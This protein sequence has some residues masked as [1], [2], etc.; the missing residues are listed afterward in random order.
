[1]AYYYIYDGIISSGLTLSSGTYMFISS[2]GVAN[3]TT[4]NSYGAMYISSGG[5]ANSTTVNDYG[6]MYI[7]SGGVHRGSLQIESGATVSAYS[8]AIFDFTVADRKQKMAT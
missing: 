1:M 6:Y 7:S 2:G 8:G 4:V 3:D 5:T